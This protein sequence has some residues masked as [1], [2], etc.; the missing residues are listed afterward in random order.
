MT[1]TSQ[2]ILSNTLIELKSITFKFDAESS[3]KKTQIITS[4]TNLKFNNHKDF[5]LFH[6]V[7][8]SLL[9]YPSDKKMMKLASDSLKQLL[10]QL[11]SNTR[12]REKLT[13]TGF[14]NTKIE[15]N[16]SYS[17]V[18]NLVSNFP[19]QISIHSSSSNSETQKSVL[20][21]I[22]PKV[23]YSKI[24]LGELDF[25]KRLSHFIT[26]STQTDL[27]WLIY[28]IQN[29]TDNYKTQEFI[30]NEL[31]IFIQW[32]INDIHSSVSF[33]RGT[34]LP[35]YFHKDLQKQVLLP[36]ILNKKLPKP[37]T[38]NPSTKQKI[39]NSAR[40]SLCYLYRET[41]P[42]TNA[43]SNDITLFNLDKGISIALFGST[44][45][46][47]Y[48]LESYIGYLVFKNNMPVSYGGGWIFGERC[49]FGINILEPFR[50]GESALIICELLR[51]YHQY[52]GVKRFVVKPYQFGF[53]NTE[54]IKTGAFWFYYK[55]GFKP[56][57]EALR[58]LAHQEDEKRKINTKYKSD[59]ATLKKFTKS[60]IEL[61][62]DK[63][64]YPDFDSEKISQLITTHINTSYSGNRQAAL[65]NCFKIMC[66]NTGIKLSYFKI[67]DL[68]YAKQIAVLLSIHPEYKQWQ[69]AH[70]K[71]ILKLITLKSST[72]E[73][74]W[75]KHLQKFDA[76]WKIVN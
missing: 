10:S 60:N 36:A 2:A 74:E 29:S 56:V 16:F 26:H 34:D 1:K 23:E 39:I 49:Q 57:N 66:K 37:V 5:K 61:V 47:R 50:G 71:N 9:A 51:T 30:F 8:L 44:I 4:L 54:A 45:E 33:L 40:L 32:N 58:K 15:C 24:H 65:D 11:N 21:L 20:K 3:L 72:T 75:I 42:F 41:E 70:K 52:F 48:S 46:K 25:K 18:C 64:T 69:T 38:L 13:G 43:N 67:H 14:Y 55:L 68:E 27:E 62:L 35:I 7:L 19:N 17:M 22:L 59:E 63:N 12:L 6:D 28:H 53:K 76:F 31:G 73:I